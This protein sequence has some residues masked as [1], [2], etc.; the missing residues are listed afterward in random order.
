MAVMAPTYE[1]IKRYPSLSV[2]ERPDSYQL[3]ARVRGF[4][5]DEIEATFA[6]GL[7]KLSPR[8]IDPDRVEAYADNGQLML[9]VPKRDVN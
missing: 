5:P 9:R 1:P 8:G 4:S 2:A 6:V 3:Q 7:A